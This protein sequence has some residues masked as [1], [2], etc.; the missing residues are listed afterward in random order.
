MQLIYCF[1]YFFSLWKR[2]INSMNTLGHRKAIKLGEEQNFLKF[3]SLSITCFWKSSLLINSK[4]AFK[5]SDCKSISKGLASSEIL[6]V[7]KMFDNLIVL[8]SLV[9]YE[10]FTISLYFLKVCKLLSRDLK[11]KI[12]KFRN[13]NCNS[14]KYKLIREMNLTKV[15]SSSNDTLVSKKNMLCLLKFLLHEFSCHFIFV[16]VFARDVLK[17]ILYFIYFWDIIYSICFKFGKLVML[18]WLITCNQK[19]LMW[20]L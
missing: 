9:K 4:I 19:Y 5:F 12:E 16:D 8:N 17:A 1:K 15:S 20:I 7:L 3:F 14:L 18:C 2:L 11:F 6:M 10:L 13:L